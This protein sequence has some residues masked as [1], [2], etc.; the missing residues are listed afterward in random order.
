MK[1]TTIHIHKIKVAKLL[2]DVNEG[3]FAIPKLQR[4]FVWDGKKAAKLLDS[5]LSGMPIG[6][7]MISYVPLKERRD[8]IKTQYA[9]RTGIGSAVYCMLLRRKPV[10]I[11]EHGLNE[12]PPSHYATAANRKDRHHIFPRGVM[13][14]VE[15]F[16]TRYNS[17]VNICLLTA[18]EN[19]QIRDKQP[20]KYLGDAR[21][22]T[23]YFRRKLDHHLVPCDDQSGIWVRDVRRGF[24]RFITQRAELVSQALEEEAGIRLFRRD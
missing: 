1:D 23:S 20:R 11:L 4:E 19:K 14:A 17:I 10:S 21:S 6:V 12:I 7:P 24:R 5:I 16:P 13:R 15:E 3:R 2:N 9:S 22:N 8:V 18:E